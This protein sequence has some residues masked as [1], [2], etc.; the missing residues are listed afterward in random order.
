MNDDSWQDSIERLTIHY[1]GTPEGCYTEKLPLEPYKPN[2]LTIVFY[3][4]IYFVSYYP[5]RLVYLTWDA[6]EDA[7]ND[8]WER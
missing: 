4:T 3:R 1:F 6:I 8:A 2:K 7:F 5:L